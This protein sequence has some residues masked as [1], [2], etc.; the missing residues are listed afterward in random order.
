[1]KL[2]AL[3]IG[4]AVGAFGV[5][6]AQGAVVITEV[7]FNEVST[8]TTGEWVEIYNSGPAAVDIS[9]YKIGD[10]ETSGG[11]SEAGGMWQFPAGTSIASG[12]VLVIAVSGARFQTVYGF[13]ADFELTGTDVNA[14]DMQAYLTWVNPAENINMNNTNDQA[15]LLDGSDAIA[16]AVSWGNTFAFSPAV[17]ITGNIDGQ[18]IQRKN[19]TIDTNTAA[20]WELG[21]ATSPAATRSTPG[22]VAVPEPASIGLALLGGVLAVGRPRRRG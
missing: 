21:P 17:D 4:L 12:D 11:D 14:A 20:D 6:S 7:C 19:A 16:D 1:M 18:S 3:G 10:E 5:T 9:N 13:S 8:D 22:V 15:V 2:R